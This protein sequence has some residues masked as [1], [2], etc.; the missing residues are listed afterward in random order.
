MDDVAGS[1][2]HT[3]LNRM[4]LGD[5]MFTMRSI[6]RLRPDPIPIDDLRLVLEAAVMAPNG[7]NTQPARFVLITDR[8]MLGKVGELYREAWWA[9]R[10]DQWGWRTIDDIPAT[11]KV[12]RSAARLADEI[13]GAPAIVFAYGR[14]AFPPELDASSVV[15]AVE[16]LMLAARA[17]GIG[18]VPTTLHP[19]VMGRIDALLGVPDTARL[20]LVIPLGYPVSATAFGTPRR[21]PTSETCFLDRWGGAVPWA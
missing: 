8:E 15:P 2:D 14:R 6:R 16:N 10:R 13:G 18:S 20:H 11:D 4:G 1:V 5:A 21:R 17:L 7:G 19:E 12:A 9:K 3:P